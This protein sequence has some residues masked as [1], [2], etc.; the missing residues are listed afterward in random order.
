MENLGSVRVSPSVLATIACLTT[1]E[2][3][4]VARMADDLV[5]GVNRLIGRSAPPSGVRV[6]FKEGRVYLDLQVVAKS[7]YS[8]LEVGSRIQEQVAESVTRLVGM[9]VGEVN[10]FVQDVE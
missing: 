3:P 4:G 9:P 2:V 10:V 8:L 1:L 6:Q 5:S 7:G